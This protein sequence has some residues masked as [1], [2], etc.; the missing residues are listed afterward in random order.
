MEVERTKER[1]H[2]MAETHTQQL[3]DEP[4]ARFLSSVQTPRALQFRPDQRAA[5]LQAEERVRAQLYHGPEPTLLVALV[6]G[7][8]VGKSSLIN[9]LAGEPIAPV[10]ETRPTTNRLYVYHHHTVSAATLPQEATADAVLIAH[11]RPELR[12][13]ILIDT[14]DLDSF[15]RAHRE[16][17]RRLLKAVG[18][19]LY[20]F[21]PE[22]YR[23]ERT[24]SVLGEEQRFSASAAVLNK[25]DQVASPE[26]LA[27][28]VDD[29]RRSFAALHL[30][31]IRIFCTSA[32]LAAGTDNGAGP[33]STSRGNDLA[34]LRAFLEREL[35]E[36]DVARLHRAQ[37]KNILGHLHAL[38]DQIAP[39]QT[40][41]QCDEIIDN[42]RQRSATV[43]TQL[44]EL[45][46][47]PLTAVERE[48]A[49]LSIIRQHERFRGPFRTWL[50]IADFL[51]FGLPRA[52]RQLVRE[53][54]VTAH[55]GVI[56]LL[57]QGRARVVEDLLR[58]EALAIQDLLYAQDLPVER[59]RTLTAPPAGG[60][61]LS[62][63]A[64]ELET[65]FVTATS[66]ALKRGG[67]LVWFLSAL[68]VLLPAAL[69][70]VGL[71]VLVR[72]FLTGVYEGLPLLGHLL[73]LVILFF[74]VLQGIAG[75]LTPGARTFKQELR[76]HVLQTVVWRT[77]DNW[78]LTY[79]ADVLAD[80]T[81][82]RRP[83]TLLQASL[84]ESP[85]GS[86]NI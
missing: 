16:R 84:L 30:G 43:A 72:D 40:I 49:P 17:T 13:K 66:G 71:Y 51:R 33:T 31:D 47:E 10:G 62:E 73:A 83:L 75:L 48:L 76:Q 63:L 85:E 50:A 21:S 42:A 41:T 74:F 82:L 9:S 60:Q 12:N 70:L 11:D 23:D 8:G 5:L 65:A 24:W 81:D 18:L 28:I 35:Q 7:T 78:L 61:L 6:G 80:L 46:E 44:S 57:L 79:R 34:A 37:R 86:L 52:V 32:V 39:E 36:S 20:V 59:W 38:V 64:E 55:G 25:S 15:A 68:G 26:E 58:K 29:L 3:L 69:V 2:A 67:M 22:K 77:I 4:L 53:K 45:L 27:L 56:H 1:P 14:P 19:V 54:T